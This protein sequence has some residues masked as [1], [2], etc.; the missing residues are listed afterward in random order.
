MMAF[1]QVLSILVLLNP[2]IIKK[3][4][5][6]FIH[7]NQERSP[8]KFCRF[9]RLNQNPSALVLLTIGR[10]MKSVIRSQSI[11]PYPVKL[12]INRSHLR[13]KPSRCECAAGV[14]GIAIVSGSVSCYAVEKKPST[15]RLWKLRMVWKG[16]RN[17]DWGKGLEHV[18]SPS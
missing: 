7:L 13:L 11:S 2:K 9:L 17:L 3:R 6:L 8:E 4:E 10:N 18:R 5:F 15:I 14:S 16:R 12:L 1:R